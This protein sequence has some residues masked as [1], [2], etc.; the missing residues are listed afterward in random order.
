MIYKSSLNHKDNIATFNDVFRCSVIVFQVFGGFS[1]PP[2]PPPTPPFTL[3]AHNWLIFSSFSKIQLSVGAQIVGLQFLLEDE[4]QK[5]T[6]QKFIDLW[7]TK[8]SVTGLV[9][10]LQQRKK[11]TNYEKA[12]KSFTML[13]IYL[14]T[15]RSNKL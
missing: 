12:T 1:F 15:Y 14:S 11:H 13:Q 10:C 6:L 5:C 3:E 7:N 2:P 9:T 8:Y 4:I